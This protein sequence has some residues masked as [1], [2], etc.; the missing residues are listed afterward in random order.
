VTGFYLLLPEFSR[1]K[2]IAIIPASYKFGHICW[3]PFVTTNAEYHQFTPFAF[4]MLGAACALWWFVI[5]D[6]VMHLCFHKRS[7]AL[8]RAEGILKAPGIPDNQRV[9][10]ALKELD[11]YNSL[12]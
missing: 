11:T 3:M 8:A 6:Y 9:S 10:L 7:G 1:L 12:K 2:F 5:A 4:L